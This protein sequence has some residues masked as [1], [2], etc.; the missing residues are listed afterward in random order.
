MA[1]IREGV[2]SSGVRYRVFDDDF[3]SE[4]ELPAV[5]ENVRRVIS[6]ICIDKARRQVE[7]EEQEGK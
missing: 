6:E 3:V 5:R 2:T 1:V 7:Q 4:A